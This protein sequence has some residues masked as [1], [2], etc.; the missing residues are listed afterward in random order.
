MSLELVP[1]KPEHVPELGRICYEAFKDIADRHH[2]PPDFPSAA[3]ARMIMAMLIQ[4]EDEYSV[5]AMMDGQVAG[6]NFLLAA[7]KVGGLGPISVEVSLQGQGIG[8]AL[9]QNV[10]D[11]G[12]TSG[13]EM[14]RLLQD[15]FNMTSLALY[16]SVGF[17]TKHPVAVMDVVAPGDPDET[18]RPV[19]PDD[20]VAIEELSTAIYR[21]SRRNEVASNIGGPFQPFLR[22][23]GGRIVGYYT[24]GMLGHGVAQTEDDM[25]SLVR[26]VGRRAPLD[27]RR[28]FCPIR[29][30][31][32][33]RRFLEAGFRNVKVM[34]LMALGPYEEPDGVWMPSVLF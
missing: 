9:M 7:D 19:T 27:G 15:A 16:A 12:R 24:L 33:Y 22:E 29:E 3:F 11:H 4:R 1:A 34:N 18:V 30:G 17:D 31:S 28:C 2:F 5:T 32:L 6:S 25:F 26:E 14:I 10:V 8:R 13:V 21:V 23:R 20:L